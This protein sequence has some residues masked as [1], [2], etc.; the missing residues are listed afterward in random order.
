VVVIVMLLVD[1]CHKVVTTLSLLSIFFTRLL[2]PCHYHVACRQ[3]CH[4][5]V[6]TL[7]DLVFLYG[8]AQVRFKGLLEELVEPHEEV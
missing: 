8:I 1:P 7:Y 5:S 4:K 3:P 6:T 2:Q